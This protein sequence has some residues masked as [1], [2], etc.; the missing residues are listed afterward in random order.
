MGQT[1]SVHITEYIRIHSSLHICVRHFQA[2]RGNSD[3]IYGKIAIK[4]I[5]VHLDSAA[6]GEKGQR[7]EVQHQTL[8]LCYAKSAEES[9][10]I[11][12]PVALS[13][14]HTKQYSKDT[15][16]C[17]TCARKSYW[18]KWRAL[19]WSRFAGSLLK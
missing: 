18:R 4:P 8:N 15:P 9:I 19:L 1:K 12:G 6:L 3:P 7:I 13:F 10:C 2:A 17:V 14:L 16:T 11:S 5:A